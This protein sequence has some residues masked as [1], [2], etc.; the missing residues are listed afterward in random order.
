MPREVRRAIIGST[1]LARGAQPEELAHV[2]SFLASDNASYVT[3]AEILVDG[4]ASLGLVIDR[5]Q[6][7]RENERRRRISSTGP[8]AAKRIPP[9]SPAATKPA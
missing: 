1:A 9:I 3:G 7:N 5:S 2:V 4:G 6:M 8:R